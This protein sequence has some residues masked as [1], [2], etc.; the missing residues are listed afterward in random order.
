VVDGKLEWVFLDKEGD[1]WKELAGAP[2]PVIQYV[3]YGKPIDQK[4]MTL[5]GMPLKK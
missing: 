5:L 2:A 3:G 1:G 4:Q